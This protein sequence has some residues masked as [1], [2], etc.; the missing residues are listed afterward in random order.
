MTEYEL[1]ETG[2]AVFPPLDALETSANIAETRAEMTGFR[3][4][5]V[6][7]LK[8]CPPQWLVRDLLEADSLALLFGDPAAGKSFICLDLAACIATG[9]PFHGHRVARPGPVFYIA[10]E[11]QNGIAR[12]LRA[13]SLANRVPLDDVP[14]L[15]S[16]LPAALCDVEIMAEVSRAVVKGAEEAGPPSLII[17]DTWSRNIGGDENSSADTA[18]AISVLD[19]LRGPWRAAGLVVHH[20][21]HGDK[22]RARGSTVLRGAVDLELRV[23]R[24]GDEVIRMDCTK[25]KDI[26]PPPSMAFR[27]EDVDLGIFDEDRRAITS[28]VLIEEEF[29]PE[30]APR[31]PS[32]KNQ[33]A[34]LEVLE[35]EIERHRANVKASGRDP[36][37]ARVSVDTWRDACAAAGLD[38]RRFSEA[39]AALLAAG[40]VQLQGGFVDIPCPS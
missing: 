22:A 2:R 26:A 36:S 24:G 5:R 20:V 9:T 37:G 23:E 31:A 17:L 14:L 32:G 40:A 1:D 28:A 6:G 21:G 33:K 34:A 10:G 35:T 19:R 27:F 8:I 7:E 15:V 30:A 29:K 3:F 38:R 11:G 12:R 39:K 18:L 4:C 25:A 16:T 13:W